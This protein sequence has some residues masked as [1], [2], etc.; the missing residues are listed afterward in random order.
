MILKGFKENSIKKKLNDVLKTSNPL[1]ENKIINSVGVIFNADEVNDFEMFKTLSEHLNIRPN[2]LK[3]IAFTEH[4][5]ENIF[6]W[7]VCFNPKDIGWKGKINNVELET[8][9][10][11]D[12]DLLISYYSKSVLELKLLTALSK[13]KFKAGIFKDDERL[14]DLIV[15]TRI[16]EF[17]EFKKELKKY[18]MVLNKLKNE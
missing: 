15:G 14:N 9:L 8:F 18:L 3:I 1:G 4:K 13:A 10:K 2:K 7:N 6:S 16:N 5:K 17:S 12:F 11:T